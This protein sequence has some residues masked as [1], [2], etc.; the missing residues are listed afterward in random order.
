MNCGSQLAPARR[1]EGRYIKDRLWIS[2]GNRN[3]ARYSDD[4]V[5]WFEVPKTPWK[6]R[7][8]ASIFV[9]DDALWVVAGNNMERDVWKLER[10]S[11]KQ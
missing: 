7:H 5:R 2:G 1:E 10:G 4:G 8:A 11:A 6:A 3:D 9:H